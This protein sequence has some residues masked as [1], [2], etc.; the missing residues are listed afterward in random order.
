MDFLKK[1]LS[2]GLSKGCV[3]FSNFIIIPLLME[4]LTLE[5]YGV[6]LTISSVTNWLLIFDLGIGLSL[7]NLVTKSV[8]E[9]NI[10]LLK[11]Y[12]TTS[13]ILLIILMS[14][15]LT[16][17]YF[18]NFYIY[19]LN[20]L[21]NF[22]TYLF[23]VAS[24][25]NKILI[26]SIIV[27]IVQK[28]I[29]FILQGFQK[30]GIAESINAVSFIVILVMVALL[31]YNN[32]K[33]AN[34]RL[35]YIAL[36]YSLVPILIYLGFSII[37]F[38]TTI[39]EFKPKWSYFD[40]NLRKDILTVG[41]KFFVIQ[42]SGIIM[43]ST[44]NLI[45]S[46]LFGNSTVSI[47]F[48][49]F[50]YFSIITI[51]FGII[52][53]PIWGLASKFYHENNINEIKKI[54]TNLLKIFIGFIIISM[55]LLY[56]FPIIYPIWIGRVLNVPDY[57]PLIMCIYSIVMCWGSIFATILNGM[58]KI[59]FQLYFTSILMI[60]NIPLSI[61]LAKYLNLGIIGIPISTM[62]CMTI[63]GILITYQYYYIIN[64][65]SKKAG[66]IENALL[67]K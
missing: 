28:N 16:L 31:K 3:I 30:V 9:N 34:N 15:I 5:E 1:I 23:E 54:T 2:V 44:D 56:L 55:I 25:C 29:V 38:S 27:L 48:I 12:I 26:S 50:R 45:I 46:H 22:P 60:I 63:G 10:L 24:I 39:K 8:T 49:P 43:Y 41:T 61:F 17:I 13:Y 57:L 21:Y 4:Y 53:T 18:L 62:I 6:W 64:Y 20:K 19:D 58:G 52:L 65:M 35:I 51:S 66:A 7:K 36:I 47:Y 59:Q 14:S 42:L 37:L 32:F 67:L 40:L 11:R 33:I